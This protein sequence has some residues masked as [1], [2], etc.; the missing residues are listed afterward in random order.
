MRFSAE[1]GQLESERVWDERAHA[2]RLDWD[3]LSAPP[4]QLT[5]RQNN[6]SKQNSPKLSKK[7]DLDHGVRSTA[8][9]SP[10]TGRAAIQ[11]KSAA[12][13]SR[14][15]FISFMSQFFIFFI[16]SRIVFFGS[17][18]KK[19]VRTTRKNK[20]DLDLGASQEWRFWC[21][22]C[23]PTN[24]ANDLIYR[25]WITFMLNITIRD[26]YDGFF[27]FVALRWLLKNKDNIWENKISI[28]A[29]YAV[30]ALSYQIVSKAFPSIEFSY[31]DYSVYR[32][33]CLVFLMFISCAHTMNHIFLIFNYEKA[34]CLPLAWLHHR[35]LQAWHFLR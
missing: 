23:H 34:W 31:Q 15:V 24:E 3:R 18:K 30:M 26:L 14:W 7:I 35:H 29:V 28:G 16:L 5:T 33:T 12:I 2:I 17:L 13:P 20:R 19:D 10:T 1:I 21:I 22:I 6:K 9:A 8:A 11:S 32:F 27:L 4:P 25:I